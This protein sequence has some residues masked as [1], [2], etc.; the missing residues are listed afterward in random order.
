M[1]LTEL[2]QRAGHFLQAARVQS[3]KSIPDIVRASGKTRQ[4]VYNWETDGP[5]FDDETLAAVERAYD[6]EP[7]ALVGALLVT[8][9]ESLDFWRGRVEEARGYAVDLAARL[10]S[11]AESMRAPVDTSRARKSIP[12]VTPEALEQSLSA[13]IR[14][15]DLKADDQERGVK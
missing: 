9:S 3:G 10:A 4:T 15:D 11:I 7:G 8:G 5:P 14:P 6:L 2:R 12:P 13:Q 1:N